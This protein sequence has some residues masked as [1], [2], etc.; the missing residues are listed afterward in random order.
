MYTHASPAPSDVSLNKRPYHMKISSSSRAIFR[1]LEVETLL[2]GVL[3]ML[4]LPSSANLL[5]ILAS[6]VSWQSVL[7]Q[8][9]FWKKMLFTHFGG[10]LPP[11]EHLNNMIGQNI[12]SADEESDEEDEEEL[13]ASLQMATRSEM[14]KMATFKWVKGVP[15]PMVL[16]V[17]CPKLTNFLR[18]AEQLSQFN[19]LI[20]IIGD[21]RVDGLA[22][23]TDY[24]LKQYPSSYYASSAIFRR[25]GPKLDD[26]VRELNI[27][28]NAGNAIVTPAFN[29]GVDK[30]IHC[31]GPYRREE[32]HMRTLQQ[33]YWSMLRCV[34]Q[35]KLH[36][37]A[38]ASIS[39]GYKRLAITAAAWVAL[40]AIQRYIRSVPWTAT[41]AIV[42]HD[43]RAYSAYTTSKA[44]VMSRFNAKY[45]R[46][47]PARDWY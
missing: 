11:A 2:E 41:I 12:D 36:C 18:S 8:N 35:E 4:D 22:F 42:C 37:V 9:H 45:L 17:A 7:N 33:T 39:T 5:E 40:R 21:E 34:Q 47:T 25:A 26:Y 1:A 19:T 27:R 28:L 16:N 20:E 23:P 15:S 24:D 31:V 30:L 13:L 46:T 43:A 6:N 32:H 29:A 38:V 14:T 10:D 44:K 3:V